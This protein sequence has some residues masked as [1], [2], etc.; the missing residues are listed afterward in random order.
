[1]H[2]EIRNF[3][4][5]QVGLQRTVNSSTLQL[6]FSS[7]HSSRSS[8]RSSFFFSCSSPVRRSKDSKEKIA[9]SNLPN[10]YSPLLSMR[11]HVSLWNA[12]IVACKHRFSSPPL[13]YHS[14]AVSD[15]PFLEWQTNVANSIGRESGRLSEVGPT[16]IAVFLS[17]L[18]SVPPC[19][20]DC[21]DYT[22]Y[23]VYLAP[24]HSL[25]ST[26]LP[27]CVWQISTASGYISYVFT[28]LRVNFTP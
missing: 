7:S 6:K 4:Q 8:S 9:N 13:H 18:P 12:H 16:A 26:R 22:D 11:S 17:L 19:L 23:S 25:G 2:R 21:V 10:S 1:M 27:L 5:H 14:A 28:G 20:S 3:R 15:R 24:V